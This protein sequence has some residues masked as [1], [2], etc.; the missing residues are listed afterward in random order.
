LILEHEGDSFIR[1]SDFLL[2]EISPAIIIPWNGID[3]P[4]IVRELSY[5]QIRACG[6][7]SL[8]ETISDIIAKKRKPTNAQILDY[9]ELQYKL[10]KASLVSPTY[11]QIMSVAQVDLGLEE[12]IKEIET[13]MDELPEGPKKDLLNKDLDILKVNSRIIL[14]WDFVSAVTAY[15]LQIGKTDIKLITED[16]LYEAAIRAKNGS[17]NPSDHLPGI[18]SEFNKVDINNR[19]MAIYYKRIKDDGNTRRRR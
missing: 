17:G 6:D 9:A 4:V 14:P 13:M 16:M 8:I 11:E 1:V 2:N 19:A 12:Q 10:I 18:F 3:C 5:A 7:F 15:A